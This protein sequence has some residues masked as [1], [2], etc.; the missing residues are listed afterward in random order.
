M[1]LRRP[2]AL[3]ATAMFA[4]PATAGAAQTRTLTYKCKYPL[5]GVKSVSLKWSQNL[6]ER[7]PLGAPTPEYPISVELSQSDMAQGLAGIEPASLSSVVRASG[8]VVTAGGQRTAIVANLTSPRAPRV[9]PTPEPLVLTAAGTVPSFTPVEPGPASLVLDKVAF[10]QAAFDEVGD[11]FVLPPVTKDVDGN[12][13]TD[14]DGDPNTYDVYCKLDPGQNTDI[15]GSFELASFD[16]FTDPNATPTPTPVP[17]PT[18]TPTP[19]PLPTPKPFPAGAT[20]EPF[21][22]KWPLWGIRDAD[23][24][25]STK[26][27]PTPGGGAIVDL[28]L[29]ASNDNE[30]DPL[31]PPPL[32]GYEFEG[33]VTGSVAAHLT[34]GGASVAKTLSVIDRE[35][36]GYDSGTRIHA[37]GT[38]TAAEFAAVGT[39]ARVAQASA[40]LKLTGV[41]GPVA[42]PVPRNDVYGSPF[43]DSDGDPSTFDVSCR[44]DSTATP[45]PTPT[46]TATATPTP[47]ATATPTPTAPP[48]AKYSYALKGSTSLNTLTKGSMPLTGGVD[49]ALVLATGDVSA[50]L[51]LNDTQGRLTA[52]GFLPVTASVG[53]VPSG[54]TTGKLV[55]DQ[56]TTNSKVRIKIKSVKAFG[57]IPLAGGNTCQSKQLS[58]ITLKS[59][60]SFDPTG[61]GGSLAGTYAISDLN[62]CGPLNGLVS[63]ITA[64]AGNTISV[65]LT[66]TK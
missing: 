63:P 40:N 28:W 57:A 23:L 37:V 47:T 25:L 6:P 36:E 44:P 45:T 5:I 19:T 13:V 56:L 53:F 10:Q 9:F 46:A 55:D 18:P 66:P 20:T 21:Q 26:A 16:V 61:T 48:S 49:A 33:A 41:S 12:K 17:T 35:T 14:S 32:V 60:D 7:V 31:S 38:L 2:L 51:Q 29:R 8:S 39:G 50:D 4:L 42:F 22:C 59:T 30:E 58:D 1:S 64:G 43:V 24:V 3:A 52:L 15:N 27:S 62:G 54:K 11:P 65:K 34:G